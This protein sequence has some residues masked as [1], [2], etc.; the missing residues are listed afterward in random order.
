MAQVTHGYE[1]GSPEYRRVTLALFLAGLATFAL[2]YTPQPL[3]PLLASEYG[4]TA[5]T[6]ALAVSVTTL[7]LGAALLVAGPV[8]EVYGRTPLMLASLFAAGAVGV[9]CGLAP[10][11]GL[12]LVLRAVQGVALAGLPAVASAYLAE[13][14]APAARAAAAGVYIGGTALGGMSG[15]L[16]TGALAEVLGWRGGLIGI[17]VLALGCAVAVWL[18]LPKSRNFRAAPSS[19]GHLARATRAIVTDPALLCLFGVAGTAMGAFVGVFNVAGF[20]L[21]AEPYSLSVGVAGLVFV[22]YA[23]GSASS[24]WAGRLVG[25]WSERT[26]APWC[27]VTAIVGV[28]IT[29]ATPLWL[30]VVGIAVMCVGFFALHGVASG[31]V[32]ARATLGAGAP[33]QA[34]SAYL[35]TYYLGSS[36]FGTLAGTVWSSGGWSRVVALAV[37][38]FAVALALTLVLKRIPSLNEVE[39]P[40]PPP[41]GA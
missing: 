27:A 5:G 2:L 4:L 1:L 15:R 7:S 17:G 10:S 36:V 32:A 20:R 11:W 30:V 3:L 26:V 33:G 28:L 38:L 13:E 19:F 29:L 25:R 21:E 35:F 31:W 12:L 41:A 16:L 37:G 40:T 9:A 22:T 14:M 23:L 18:L 6:S 34:S 24:A 8:S 39:H